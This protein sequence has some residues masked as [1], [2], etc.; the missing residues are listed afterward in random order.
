MHLMV[1]RLLWQLSKSIRLWGYIW[2]VGVWVFTLCA[3]LC[4]PMDL[5]AIK[6]A[7]LLWTAWVQARCNH[8]KPGRTARVCTL[9][10]QSANHAC[11]HD[12]LG[13]VHTDSRGYHDA[14]F[15]LFMCGTL[16]HSWLKLPREAKWLYKNLYLSSQSGN[17]LVNATW[18]SWGDQLKSAFTALAI[19]S[20]IR[21]RVRFGQENGFT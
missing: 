18:M 4:V 20:V 6:V 16:T 3:V 17:I 14:R 11:I 13:C 5:A 21:I 2:L 19:N 12:R 15:S 8:S 9:T 1:Q 7:F 10:V